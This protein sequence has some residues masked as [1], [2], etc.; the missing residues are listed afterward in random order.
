LRPSP[1]PSQASILELGDWCFRPATWEELH[2]VGNWRRF[3]TDPASYF[4][5]LLAEAAED[6]G[7]SGR[8]R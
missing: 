6:A 1:A 2:L 5:Q 4:R 7:D 8:A 3:M